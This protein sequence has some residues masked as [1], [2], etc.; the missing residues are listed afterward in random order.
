MPWTTMFG[1][2]GAEVR[3]FGRTEGRE[4]YDANREIFLHAYEQGLQYAIVD[5][6]R[7]DYLDLLQA[8]L[9]RVA[10][11]DRQYLLRNPSYLLAV[12]APQAHVSG[13]ARTFQLFMEGSTLRSVVVRTRDEAL[14]WLQTE[15]TETAA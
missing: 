15:L 10:E 14:A 8:D 6:S 1:P 12:I 5:F 4:V 9:L 7:V 3:F 2:Q 11:C 13:L